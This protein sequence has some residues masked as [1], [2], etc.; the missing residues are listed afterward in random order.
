MSDEADFRKLSWN[1]VKA[2]GGGT[3]PV[4]H[5]KLDS[6]DWWRQPA[7]CERWLRFPV[8]IFPGSEA[9]F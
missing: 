5:D 4:T 2:V 7:P 8:P 6:S 3:V 1:E 9:L